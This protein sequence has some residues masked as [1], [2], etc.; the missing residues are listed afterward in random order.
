MTVKSGANAFVLV[1]G[2]KVE[3]RGDNNVLGGGGAASKRKAGLCLK[4]QALA[5]VAQIF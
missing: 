3:R 4:G 2:A 5:C 1:K